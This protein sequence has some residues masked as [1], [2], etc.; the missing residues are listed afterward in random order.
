MTAESVEGL[1]IELVQFEVDMGELGVP[2]QSEAAFRQLRAVVTGK[3]RD[4][5]DLDNVRGGN[6]T[7]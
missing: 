2:L 6:V 1:M 7:P 4:V 5:L 3:A